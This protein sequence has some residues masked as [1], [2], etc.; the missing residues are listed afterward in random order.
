[1]IAPTGGQIINPQPANNRR[2]F[3]QIQNVG[4]NEGNFWFERQQNS[5]QAERLAPTGFRKY[6]RQCPTSAVY[7]SSAL[8][9]MFS[10]TE[11]FEVGGGP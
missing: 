2:V 9:T 1:V 4:M 7:Y 5:G 8:G 11:S 10:V 3:L 6:D